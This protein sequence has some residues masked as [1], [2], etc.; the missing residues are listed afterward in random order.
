ML[1]AMAQTGAILCI[2]STKG[3]STSK[4]IVLAGAD[5]FRWKR[6]VGPGDVLRIELTVLKARK[7]F[8]VNQGRITV[9]GE[10]VCEGILRAAE[11]SL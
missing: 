8:W 9:D 2:K 6:L 5:E 11:T 7:A 10:L 4:N 3:G 1:E